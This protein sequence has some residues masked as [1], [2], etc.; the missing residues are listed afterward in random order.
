LCLDGNTAVALSAYKLIDTAFCFPIT[1]S[2]VMPENIEMYS[3]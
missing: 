2:S 1:P 3:A